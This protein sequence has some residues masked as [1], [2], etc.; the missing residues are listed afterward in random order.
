MTHSAAQSGS[1]W[2]GESLA[3]ERGQALGIRLAPDLS[4]VEGEDGQRVAFTR[5][6]RRVLTALT[7]HRD[8][9][10]TRE[11]LLD[12]VAGPGSDHADRNIDFLINRLRH[13]LCDDARH[14]RFIA[15]RYGEGYIW[16][17]PFPGIDAA[18]AGAYLVLGPLRGID[19]LGDG[20]A[21]ATAYASHLLAALRA[22]LPED[23]PAVLAPDCP[24]PSAFPEAAPTVSIELT[25]FEENGVMHCVATG[26][27]FRSRQV[28]AVSRVAV[29]A[30]GPAATVGATAALA[31]SLLAEAWRALATQT[32]DGVPVP[33]MMQ[34]ASA[35]AADPGP[36]AAGDSLA[37]LQQVVS[38]H[39]QRIMAAWRESGA[40]LRNLLEATPDEPILK[41]MYATH[42]H[43]KY[44]HFGYSLF[45]NGVDERAQDEDEIE[46]LVLEA[47][48][49]VQSHPE[50][51]IMAAKLL[52]FLRRGYFD[53]ARELSERAYATSVS[54]AGS[55]AMIGQFR[56]FAGE[57]EAALRCL[58]QA[59]GL[60]APG[61]PEYF[62]IL[63]M[64]LQAL[65]AAA[66]FEPL[67]EA[68]RD[69]YRRS[70]A[71]M[72]LYEPL[73]AHPERP[74]LRAKA[75]MLALSQRKAA[76]FL[77]WQHYISARLF[78]V[79]EHR[80]NV[81]LPLLTLVARRFGP[82]AVPDE[83]KAAYPGLA[84]PFLP[85]ACAGP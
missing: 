23:K 84:V 72:L 59:I 74:S 63:T 49:R 22:E 3:D 29:P 80:H 79:P 65:H 7:Q 37:H 40:R 76:G 43:T 31:R 28:L 32:Q 9:I 77:L 2:R 60:S 39:E 38:R 83:I 33:V 14:P 15:T 42:I 64:K 67:R 81:I 45:Q 24:P 16:T 44:V 21:V 26:R 62:Y 71:L 27:Q 50:Y 10:V 68:K 75:V 56:A 46:R 61:S 4:Y 70:P 66:R 6:E 55:L 69:V 18:Q 5:S 57:T 17:G 48:P 73:F 78:R 20:A 35:P 53:L 1:C 11:Q 85:D 30:E 58:D 82:S 52:H 8:R 12:A 19:N 47:L 36:G 51:A 41:V 25:F 13:K 54:A 34:L